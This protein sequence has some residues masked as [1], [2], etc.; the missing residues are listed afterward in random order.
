VA[1]RKEHEAA[2]Q[3]A[4]QAGDAECEAQAL[5]GLGDAQYFLGRLATG[6]DYFLRC[7]GLCE[8]AGLA[9]VEIP[10]R[11][12]VG[13]CLYYLNRIEE[14]IAQ[15]RLSLDEARRI[16]QAHSE[17]FALESLGFL[18]VGTGDYEAAETAILSGIPIAR[19]AGA[20]RYLAMMLYALARVRLVEG[21]RDEAR[22]HLDEG[23]GTGASDRNGFCRPDDTVGRRR[24]RT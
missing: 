9:K 7:V 4:E 17:I 21:S 3:H 6:L 23:A 14:S 24:R 19:T 12:M 16:G 22:A 2:L 15:I 8:R 1:C 13:H 5:S 10:N 20:R 18:L 11:C